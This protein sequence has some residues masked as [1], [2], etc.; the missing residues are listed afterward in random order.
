[1]RMRHDFGPQSWLK[2]GYIRPRRDNS[3]KAAPRVKGKA[4]KQAKPTSGPAPTYSY[5]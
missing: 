4:R 1:M 3:A 2:L 5:I